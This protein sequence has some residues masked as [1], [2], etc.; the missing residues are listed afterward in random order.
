MR[1]N[2]FLIIL[3]ILF[4]LTAC[5]SGK[6]NDQ[7]VNAVVT[8]E[9]SAGSIEVFG[10][11]VA[12]DSKDICVDFPAFIQDIYV[13]EGQT[14]KKGDKLINLNY[15]QFKNEIEKKSKEI[16]LKNLELQSSKVNINAKENELHILQSKLKEKVNHLSKNTDPDMQILNSDLEKAM[17]ELETARKDYEDS[18]QLFDI[19]AVSQRQLEEYK[20]IV[21]TK[22]KAKK[23]IL[24]KLEKYKNSLNEEVNR[25]TTDISYKKV[26][27]A[28][29]Q[30]GSIS[31]LE[32]QKIVIESYELD[33]NT[34]KNKIDKSYI[35]MDDI[36]SDIQNGIVSKI[37][38]TEGSP[39]GTSGISNLLSI[40]DADSIQIIA[41]VPEEFIKDVK[42]GAECNITSY[43]DK[44][45]VIEGKVIQISEMAIKQ[46]GEKVV[47]VYISIEEKNNPLKPGF[48]VDVEIISK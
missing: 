6:S 29:V 43:Y 46:N 37:T 38:C 33:M 3:C 18:K 17:K 31:A 8:E 21:D 32:Q 20:E 9:K 35:V 7:L 1:K 42:F 11:V 12:L 19:G 24:Q 13:Q 39:V 22:E 14:I 23:D 47:K 2:I 10:E 40:I 28:R 15:N 27:L 25:L 16:E 26:D 48:S 34:M 5:S 45:K 44:S 41:D 30:G 36:V 4:L